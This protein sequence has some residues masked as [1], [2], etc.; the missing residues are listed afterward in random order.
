MDELSPK[1]VSENKMPLL[2]A[3]GRGSLCF[4]SLVIKIMLI[5]CNHFFNAPLHHFRNFRCFHSAI[6]LKRDRRQDMD[7]YIY[8]PDGIGVEGQIAVD[9]GDRYDGTLRFDSRLFNLF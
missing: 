2:Y 4:L 3:N 5:L 1:K 8:L 6:F 7:L 9:N